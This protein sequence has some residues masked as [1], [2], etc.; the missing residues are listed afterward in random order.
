MR[1]NVEHFM[2]SFDSNMKPI[3][4]QQTTRT[5]TN[6]ATVDARINLLLARAAASDCDVVVKGTLAG[7]QRGW[8]RL[9]GGTFQSDRIAE[10]PIA[11]ATLRAVSDTAGQDLTYTCVPP[12][13]GERIGVDRDDDG[14]YD[15]DEAD[16]GTDAGNPLSFPGPA[17]DVLGKRLLVKD[18][19]PNVDETKR[20]VILIAK[21]SGAPAITGNPVADGASLTIS[22]AGVLPTEQ[23][24]SLPNTGWAALGTAGYRYTDSAGANG[25]VKTVI[26]KRT[27]AGRMTFKVVA[28]G[29]NGLINLMPPNTGTGGTAIL[30]IGTSRYCT[31]LGG[32][33]GGTITS[34]SETLF[35]VKN[36]TASVVCP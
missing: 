5:S 25:P 11:E 33:A 30:V 3:V 32:A 9:S 26:L 4:G 18:L 31:T 34:N 24:F 7:E 17:T 14:V 8:Y 16:A 29:G 19:R 20:R 12:G 10:T 23:A 15:G 6:G 1:R 35:K 22:L 2:H 27:N 21:R 36:P 13:S 28:L